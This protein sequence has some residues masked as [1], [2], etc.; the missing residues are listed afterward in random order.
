MCQKLFQKVGYNGEEDTEILGFYE[1]YILMGGMWERSSNMH[2]FLLSNGEKTSY[3]R[4]R[5]QNRLTFQ[6]FLQLPPSLTSTQVPSR[7]CPRNEEESSPFL[8]VCNG[9]A[10][11]RFLELCGQGDTMGE[12]AAKLKGSELMTT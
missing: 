4:A 9:Y 8:L 6:L 7:T 3:Y 12:G 1:V 5:Q 11:V 2:S 10:V